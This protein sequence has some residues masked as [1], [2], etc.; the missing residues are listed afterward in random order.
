V[1]ITLTCRA[2]KQVPVPSIYFIGKQ[3][4]PLEIVTEAKD[5][6]T[7]Q[8]TLNAILQKGGMAPVGRSHLLLVI[9]LLKYLIQLHRPRISSTMKNQQ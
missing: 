8:D 1:C 2:D 5:V 9:P 6:K 4:V 3:G 7:F